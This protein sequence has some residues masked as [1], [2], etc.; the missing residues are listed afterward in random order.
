MKY[1]EE[2]L[3]TKSQKEFIDLMAKRHKSLKPESIKRT[4]YKLRAKYGNQDSIQELKTPEMQTFEKSQPIRID[5][6]ALVKEPGQ[7]K[8]LQYLDMKR[9]KHK[10]TKKYLEKNGF[11]QEEI[12][13]MDER[14]MVESEA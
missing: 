11:S 9:Y 13:W 5:D 6:D 4:W 7:L 1:R 2:Y 12:N 8:L 14:G 10:T 3:E